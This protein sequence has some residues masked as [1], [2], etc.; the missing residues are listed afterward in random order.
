MKFTPTPEQ[1]AILTN[2]RTE[3][4]DYLNELRWR[5]FLKM[6]IP[7]MDKVIFEPGAGIGDQ[8]EW[9]LNRGAKHIYVNDGRPDNL[10]IIRDRF[11]SN[12]RLTFVEG[13]LENCLDKEEFNFTADLIFLWG[14]YY[15][16]DDSLTEFQIMRGLSRIAPM[17]V[18]DYLESAQDGTTE[19]GYDNPST[20][21]SQRAI[22]LTTTTLM[23]GLRKVWG[24]AYLP[25]AQM[26]WEDP[27]A[28][29]TP[30]RLAVA[31]IAP[32]RNEQLEEQ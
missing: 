13:N 30:R 1:Q 16:I 5:L 19:Y 17:V 28:S 11:R 7:I 10:Q 29:G 26:D 12:P 24:H 23:R 3:R 4:Y 14:V 9:L 22:R 18:F 21:V 8:T 2:F 27:L 25:K 20:S 15:H 31:S 6:G 32:L